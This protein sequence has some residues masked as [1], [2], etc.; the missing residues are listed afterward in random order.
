MLLTTLILVCFS[1]LFWC[2][3]FGEVEGLSCYVITREREPPVC[4]C[5]WG[6]SLKARGGR[7]VVYNP[8]WDV[9]FAELMSEVA[10]ECAS[11]GGIF[12]TE[13]A[14]FSL[15]SL[16]GIGYI[17]GPPFKVSRD[18]P[19]QTN[20]LGRMSRRFRKGFSE[21]GAAY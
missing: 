3:G 4:V 20:Q 9:P 18:Y 12:L 11:W 13:K 14:G 5:G 1:G 7:Q 10:H 15:L 19:R 8:H 6:G 2:W 16:V 21:N 17:P